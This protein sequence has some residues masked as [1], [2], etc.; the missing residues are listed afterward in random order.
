MKAW[1]VIMAELWFKLTSTL[2]LYFI[3]TFKVS[4]ANDKFGL[5]INMWED[6]QLKQFCYNFLNFVLVCATAN[7][8]NVV[9][10]CVVFYDGFLG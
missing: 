8:L 2:G 3:I 9:I 5:L 10:I 7:Y 4:Q 6:V 1:N